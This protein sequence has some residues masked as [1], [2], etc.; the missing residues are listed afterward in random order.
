M[1]EIALSV[2]RG[3]AIADEPR[4]LLRPQPAPAAFA[5]RQGFA[6]AGS[7]VRELRPGGPSDASEMAAPRVDPAELEQLRRDAYRQGM[8][9]GRREGFAEG[10]EEGLQKGQA[11]GR[12]LGQDAVLRQ[13]Q[14]ARHDLGTLIDRLDQLL[15]TLP[16]QFRE[17]LAARLAACEDDM[18]A[19][20]HAAICRLLGERALDRDAI[21]YAVRQA[22][23]ECS[24]ANSHSAVSRLLAIH[25]HPRDL[26]MLRS[27]PTLAAW[28]DRHGS[29]SMIPWQADDSVGLGGCIV[30]T[31][32]GSL[33]ARLETQLAALQ[34]ILLSGRT[35]RPDHGAA[36]S[37]E[38]GDRQ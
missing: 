10:R 17:S 9:Q 18:V 24:G 21:V 23:V 4:A 11:E 30:H 20:S 32:Q 8:E 28:L 33:D 27:D 35:S 22:I 16:G 3:L 25:V 37:V 38:S 6:A 2:L 5:T 14:A 26:E 19:L 31:A 15:A 12:Q 13:T 36:Q 29:G 7:A 1:N 34:M